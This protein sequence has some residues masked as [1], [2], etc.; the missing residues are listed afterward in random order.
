[1]YSSKSIVIH[2]AKTE[3]LARFLNL[4]CISVQGG[5]SLGIVTMKFAKELEQDLVPEWRVKYLDYKQGK[6]KV[7]AVARAVNRATATPRTPAQPQLRPRAY[8]TYGATSSITPR[9]KVPST[10]RTHNGSHDLG[11]VESLRHSPAPLGIDSRPA[12]HESADEA[13]R[14][15]KKTP[16]IPVPTKK[17]SESSNP[18]GYFGSFVPTPPAATTT[19]FELPDPA[20][21][22]QTPLHATISNYASDSDSR[23]Q[24][25]ARRSAS[26][27]VGLS[28]Y[29]VGETTSPNKFTFA[30]LRSHL[31]HKQNVRPFMKRI[32]SVGGPMTPNEITRLEVDMVAMDHVRARQKEFFMW[33]DKELD[34]VESFYKLKE[35]EAG[36]RLIILREQLHEMRNRRIEEL[37]ELQRLKAARKDD[38]R[39]VFDFYGPRN[40]GELTKDEDRSRPN[41]RDHLQGWLSPFERVIGETKAKI[42]K[43]GSNSKALA[44]MSPS[45]V[46][47][48]RN[49]PGQDYVRRH[50]HDNNVPYRSA[51]RK[52]KL[53]LQ[54]YYRGMEL[55]KSYALL[56]RTGFRKINKKYDK[57]AHAHPP[58]RYMSEKVNQARFVKSDIL[59]GYMHAVE[60]LYARYFERGNHKIATGKLRG[61]RNKVTDQSASAFRNGVLI[62]VGAVFSTQGLIY[63]STLLN[64]DDPIIRVRTSYLLQVYGGYF[65]ALY[66]FSWFCLACSIW[67]KNKINYQFVFEFDTRH[68]LDWREL[69]E[70]P[71]FFILLLGLFVWLNFSRYGAPEMYIYYPV[72]LIFIT[73]LIIFLPARTIFHRSRSWFVYSHNIELFFCLYAHFWSNPPRC[74]SSHSRLL[75]FFS[76]LPGIWRAL[77]CIRRY[78]DTRNIFPHLVNCGKYGMTIMFGVTL[79]LYRIQRSNSMLALF[80]TFATIN[81]IYCIIWDLFM[82]W[83]LLQPDAKKRF[84]RDVRGYKNPKWYYLAMILDPILRFNWILYSIYTHDLQHSTIASFMVAFSEV[85]RRGM[86][87][88]FRVENEHCSNVAR[89]KASRDVPLPYNI[90]ASLDDPLESAQPQQIPSSDAI[91]PIPSIRRSPTITRHRSRTT[92]ASDRSQTPDGEFRRRPPTRTFTKILADAHTQDFEKKRKPGASVA[93]N[94]NALDGKD[95]SKRAEPGNIDLLDSAYITVLTDSVPRRSVQVRG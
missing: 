36:E 3:E 50:H 59:D 22:P 74:N 35:D 92:G 68:N 28:A 4:S 38:D 11:A 29:E 57:A 90:K 58:L 72:I 93:A 63:A 83:S 70:F 30:S 27:P 2:P 53:A 40:N 18:G 71:S 34:K 89:F 19:R 79:S 88:I 60:D 24:P 73:A 17:N 62:G 80:T 41:S 31:A 66:L 32:F 14:K 37:A 77:Q 10:L 55:L 15:I 5:L 7:K 26:I 86:W 65:L 44:K 49:D 67:T 33:M 13:I 25:K 1:M 94:A 43:P 16:P 85:T 91:E 81:S 42:I 56:N 9:P 54:E 47:Q 75:G 52:L 23:P 6:K 45:P 95:G 46:L 8:S 20:V 87:T 51:K 64:H 82:D 48:S 61:S 84:L 78:Y 21:S 39:S 69:S 76:T 12:S